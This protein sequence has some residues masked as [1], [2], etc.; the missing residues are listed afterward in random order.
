M[1]HVM[2]AGRGAC[3]NL[4]DHYGRDS[5][6]EKLDY[7]CR[8]NKNIDP[9]RTYMNYNLAP[10]GDQTE[11]L[12][13]RLSEVK[14]LNRKDVNVIC[15]WAVTMPKTLRAEDEKRFFEETYKFLSERY[16]EQ[17]VISAYVHKDETTPHMHFCFV[18][19]I[20]EVDKKGIEVE[21]VNAK[22][23][24]NRHELQVFHKQLGDHLN[25]VLGYEVGI[26]NGATKEGNL[27]VPQL[28][29]QTEKAQKLE[30]QNEE[31]EVKVK[32]LQ[33]KKENIIEDLT[34][35][36]E[37]RQKLIKENVSYELKETGMFSN[38][39]KRAVWLELEVLDQL[40][41]LDDRWSDLKE[42]AL[43]LKGTN[44]VLKAE[45]KDLRNAVQHMIEYQKAL[46]EIIQHEVPHKS[47]NT[48]F[49]E[50]DA[51]NRESMEILIDRPQNGIKAIDHGNRNS[52]NQR[53]E[54]AKK[55]VVKTAATK[56]NVEMPK[57]K[58][59]N[60]ER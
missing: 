25:R 26:E 14:C 59:N 9:D 51:R 41:G 37:K 44:D 11:R 34:K 47:L 39:K 6:H 24:I 2:K 10:A 23:V 31:L 53:L 43:I 4:F 12:R 7:M 22:K 28:K 16:G 27:T 57:K 48:L 35:G 29:A 42:R 33:R 3:G 56:K 40:L 45:N 36:I 18:P 55:S 20:K 21:K 50:R 38:R 8:T 17:N 15:T 1:A 49:N 32:Q 54:K 60:Q 5:E 46:E 19:V 30:K 13:K 52:I 58:S